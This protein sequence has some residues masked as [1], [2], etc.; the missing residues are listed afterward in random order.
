MPDQLIQRPTRRERRRRSSWRFNANSG[1]RSKH[2]ALAV[3]ASMAIAT[4]VA[5]PALADEPPETPI[6]E[7]CT[8]VVS[9]GQYRLC[10]TLNPNSYAKLSYYFLINVAGRCS[11]G[12]IVPPGETEVEG[13]K[14]AVE[15]EAAGLNPGTE[16][17]YCLVATNEAATVQGQG[18]TFIT[19]PFGGSE[20]PETPVTE[21]CSGPEPGVYKLCGT[22]NP[23]RYANVS[24]VFA[25]NSGSSCTGGSFT[26]L[27]E[28][29]DGEAIPVSS[30]QPEL[31]PATEY[32]DC[33]VAENLFGQEAYGSP[34]TFTTVAKRPTVT[35]ETAEVTGP[36]SATLRAEVELGGRTETN[37]AFLYSASAAVT[38]EGKLADSTMAFATPLPVGPFSLG[39]ISATVI[40]LTPGGTYYYQAIAQNRA[41]WSY[42]E[43]RSFTTPIAE[44]QAEEEVRS[45]N[46]PPSES[47]D[48]TPAP[49]SQLSQP[50]SLPLAPSPSASAP[51]SLLPHKPLTRAQ[52]LARAVKQC[53]KKPKKKRAGCIKLAHKKYGPRTSKK[54]PERDRMSRMD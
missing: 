38:A 48:S 26:T 3:A 23:H 46:P 40:E 41:G 36:P 10:G 15:I 2:L 27:E 14:I 18:V 33:V 50:A 19:E 21:V 25:Y 17:T 42:G 22:L 29:L 24:S 52:K 9:P 37:Y 8:S 49:A 39:A 30:L 7:A 12:T 16:Y 32:T 47:N 45:E 6:T 43:V 4:G 5:T 34:V 20:P 53:K 31:E 51:Q 28:K 11:G 35:G 44:T 1:I 54:K 13:E